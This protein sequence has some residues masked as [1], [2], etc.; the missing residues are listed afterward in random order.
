MSKLA[1]V[2]EP[3][4]CWS[5]SNAYILCLCLQEHLEKVL[6]QKDLPKDKV[7]EIKLVL[8]QA[9]ALSVPEMHKAM[10]KYN[11]KAPETGNDIT[12]P[13]PFN[14]MFGTQIGPS[15][16]VKGYLFYIA[17]AYNLVIFDQKPLKAC[18]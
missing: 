3:I 10:Q 15:G 16:K 11:V 5:V 13:E 9:D 1:V 2:T 12:E 4:T 18:S 17:Y 14:L 6:E 7:E 8:A